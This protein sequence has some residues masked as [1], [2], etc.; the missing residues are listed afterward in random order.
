MIKQKQ[1]TF[2]RETS[3]YCDLGRERHV[4]FLKI[5]PERNFKMWL[6]EWLAL[7]MAY[8]QVSLK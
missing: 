2:H 7:L 1:Y 3:L 5:E 8:A 4:K 6:C